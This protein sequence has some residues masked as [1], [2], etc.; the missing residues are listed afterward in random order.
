GGVERMPLRAAVLGEAL[1]EEE[2]LAEVVEGHALEVAR[3][4]YA[5]GVDVLAG[6]Q[7]GA[8]GDLGDAV[9]GHQA[10]TPS[11]VPKTWRASVTTPV[12]AAAATITGLMRTVRP[13]GEPC[14]PLKLRFDDEAQSWSPTSLSGF[15]ARHMLQ[16][17]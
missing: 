5:I 15:I 6:D 11:A 17:A 8:T 16:P 12:M 2:G 14:L 4:D 13:L 10:L 9:K 3:R 7:H 1:V